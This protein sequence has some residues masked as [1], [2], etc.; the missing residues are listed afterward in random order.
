M[1]QDLYLG[2]RTLPEIVQAIEQCD[3]GIIPNRRNI[4]T[5][6]NMPTRIFECLALA[7][8]VIAP[9]T[10]GIQDYFSEQE[11]VYFEPDNV[12]DLARKIIYVATHPAEVRD[13]VRRGQ[14]VYQQH[15]W[16]Q[17]RALFL[18]LCGGSAGGQNQPR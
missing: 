18:Q 1:R 7:K 8:P 11:H 4:F 2:K 12:A 14:A 3:V 5:E 16:L 6:I 10:H 13:I 15:L 9:S 17:E